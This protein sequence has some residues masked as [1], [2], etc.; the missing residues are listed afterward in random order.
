MSLFTLQDFVLG[1][2][3]KGKNKDMLRREAAITIRM[4][5][6]THGNNHFKSIDS[7]STTNQLLWLAS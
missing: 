1:M 7:Y 4:K 2:K 6:I 5:M 3:V